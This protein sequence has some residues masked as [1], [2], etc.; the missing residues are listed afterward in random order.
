MFI[1]GSN[2]TEYFRMTQENMT[3]KPKKTNKTAGI[4]KKG[5]ENTLLA[6]NR[7][8]SVVWHGGKTR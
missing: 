3:L 6:L 7:E 2:A 1:P 4:T 5:L 8:R